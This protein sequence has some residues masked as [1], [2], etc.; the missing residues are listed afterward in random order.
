MNLLS[1]A[2]CGGCLPEKKIAAVENLWKK[3]R[4]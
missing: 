2:R 3:R 1:T 4:R